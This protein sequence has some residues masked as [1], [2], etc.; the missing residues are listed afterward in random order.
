MTN[1][2]SNEEENSPHPNYLA[3]HQCLDMLMEHL[4]IKMDEAEDDVE[5]VFATAELFFREYNLSIVLR[6]GLN[7]DVVIYPTEKPPKLGGGGGLTA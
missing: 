3:A 1:N 5:A 4:F 7:P 2:G 6:M